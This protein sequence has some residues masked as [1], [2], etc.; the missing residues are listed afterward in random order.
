MTAYQ[1]NRQRRKDEL[2]SN[3]REYFDPAL[4]NIAGLGKMLQDIDDTMYDRGR[5][6][7]RDE[8][9]KMLDEET[10]VDKQYKRLT[11]GFDREDKRQALAKKESE[12]RVDQ[13]ALADKRKAEEE[14]IRAEE[15]RKAKKE[16]QGVAVAEGRAEGMP[17]AMVDERPVEYDKRGN[18][19]LEKPKAGEGAQ[20]RPGGLRKEDIEKRAG[21]AGMS[22]ALFQSEMDKIEDEMRGKRREEARDVAESESKIAKDAAIANKAMRGPAGPKPKTPEQIAA[23]D[24]KKTIEELDIEKRRRE[25]EGTKV[26]PPTEAQRTKQDKLKGFEADV[27]DFE[28]TLSALESG[29]GPTPGL[30][31]GPARSLWSKVAGDSQWQDFDSAASALNAQSF[32]LLRT[33]APSESENKLIEGLKIN[34]TDNPT[35]IKSKI[36]KLK[37]LIAARKADPTSPVDQLLSAGPSK[38]RPTGASVVED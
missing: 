35:N 7:K 38:A 37:K 19:K 12:T 11:E 8:R 22:P 28:G 33:D 23:D 24:R 2:A 30:V 6:E 25:L 27:A 36:A 13:Q 18:I 10:A 16:A 5:D 26:Q 34:A 31:S 21:A 3:K 17:G 32:G 9:Q 29:A 20:M 1:S 4:Q 15:E 14:K